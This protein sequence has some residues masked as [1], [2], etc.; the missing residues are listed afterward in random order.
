MNGKKLISCLLYAAFVLLNGYAFY[1]EWSPNGMMTVSDRILVGCIDVVLLLTAGLFLLSG[2]KDEMKRKRVLRLTLWLL[3]ITYLLYL[4]ILLFFSA[5][6]GRKWNPYSHT[7]PLEYSNFIPFKTILYYIGELSQAD[8]RN[9]LINLLGNLFAFFPMG[10]FLP[11]LFSPLRK[12]GKFFLLLF[13][14]LLLI[15]GAQLLLSVGSCD[16]DDI[17][18]NAAGAAAAFA[19][20]RSRPFRKLTRDF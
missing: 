11:L 2:Q 18:L 19:L 10:I 9:S 7:Q 14:L 5:G 6:F 16:I 13:L 4:L 1:M 12:A 15:E 20:I 3:F 17:L 8:T